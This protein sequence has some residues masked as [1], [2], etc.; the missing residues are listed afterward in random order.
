M[1]TFNL[2]PKTIAIVLFR[3]TGSPLA[4]RV[5]SFMKTFINQF[6]DYLLQKEAVYFVGDLKVK[7]C[8]NPVTQSYFTA[9]NFS[10]NYII[11]VQKCEVLIG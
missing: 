11:N 5:Y 4:S 6:K 7:F 9:L 1:K 10:D 2:F 8:F 3:T